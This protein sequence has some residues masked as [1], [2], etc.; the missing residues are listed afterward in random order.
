MLV[1]LVILIPLWVLVLA[2]LGLYW[3]EQQLLRHL[4][5][6]KPTPNPNR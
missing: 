3:T 6:P 1:M 2:L 5:I 4:G